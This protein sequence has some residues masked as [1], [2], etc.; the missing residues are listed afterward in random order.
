MWRFIKALSE[1]LCGKGR[2][3]VAKKPKMEGKRQLRVIIRPA[4][5]GSETKKL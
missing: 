2:E 3:S 5:Y 4:Y 1:P